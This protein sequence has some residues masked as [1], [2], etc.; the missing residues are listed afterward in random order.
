MFVKKENPNR[1]FDCEKDPTLNACKVMILVARINVDECQGSDYYMNHN[2]KSPNRKVYFCS[3]VNVNFLVG[4]CPT[5]C[6]KD[7]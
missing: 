2:N 4:H 3:V 6:K 1:H 5:S 7:Q